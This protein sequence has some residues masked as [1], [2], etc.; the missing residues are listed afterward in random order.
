MEEEEEVVVVV[1]VVVVVV[2]GEEDHLRSK[3]RV[4]LANSRTDEA[5]PPHSRA[6]P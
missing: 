5:R 1:F 6:S 2:E 4:A 3:A